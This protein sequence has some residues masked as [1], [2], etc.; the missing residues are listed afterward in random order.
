ME[1]DETTGLETKNRPL[2][3]SI[4]PAEVVPPVIHMDYEPDDNTEARPQEDGIHP[5]CTG[6]VDPFKPDHLQLNVRL[7]I[8]N[9]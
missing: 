9:G 1:G 5:Q 7:S 4:H 8:T 6:Q 3:S 2:P